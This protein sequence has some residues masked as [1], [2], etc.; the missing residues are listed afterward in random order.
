MTK[1]INLV[2]L[3]IGALLFNPSS[4]A[5]EGQILRANAP[6][7]EAEVHNDAVERELQRRRM[8]GKGGKGKGGM[9]SSKGGGGGKN[10]RFLPPR[11]EPIP[12]KQI[13]SVL[14]RASQ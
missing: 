9:M 6:A 7:R 5:V 12:G 4:F 13:D 8:N 10:I 11:I 14:D 2:L 3:S 1:I